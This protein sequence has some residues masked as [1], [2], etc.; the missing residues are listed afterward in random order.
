MNNQRKSWVSR[1]MQMI[2]VEVSTGFQNLRSPRQ[3]RKG[4]PEEILSE[5]I[6][7]GTKQVC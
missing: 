7:K 4:I 1:P 2:M 6:W 3:V 5:A